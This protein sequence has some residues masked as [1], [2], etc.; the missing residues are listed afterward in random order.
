M[1]GF[2]RAALAYRLV[3]DLAQWQ[4]QEFVLS[5]EQAHYLQRVLRLQVGDRFVALDGRGAAR[6]AQLTPTGARL[7]EALA[8]ATELPIAVQLLVALP[9]GSGFE[10]IVRCCTELG[11]TALQ[12]II[13]DRTLLKPSANRHQ[14]WQKIAQEAAEQCERAIVPHIGL[15]DDFLAVLAALKPSSAARYICVARHNAPHLLAVLEPGQ[16]ATIATGPEGG[17]SEREIQGAIAV[18]FQPVTLGRRILRAITAPIAA[19]T[20]VAA[21]AEKS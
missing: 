11:V 15:P 8:I 18:G 7:L 5:L 6:M 2:R 14:R 4:Q 21:V 1:D 19:L 3:I 9:K 13:S 16:D 17:W 12:P 20:L 10:D